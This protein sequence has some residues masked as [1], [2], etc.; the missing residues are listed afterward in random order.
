[1]IKMIRTDYTGAFE[2]GPILDTVNLATVEEILNKGH[3]T[4]VGLT[5]EDGKVRTM[6]ARDPSWQTLTTD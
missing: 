3:W 2:D 1:M 5:I 4:L 6:I